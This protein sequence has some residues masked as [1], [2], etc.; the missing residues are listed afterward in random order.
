ME[1]GRFKCNIWVKSKRWSMKEKMLLDAGEKERIWGSQRAAQHPTMST[2]VGVSRVWSLKGIWGSWKSPDAQV[3][4]KTW[5]SAPIV[6]QLLSNANKSRTGV[7][8]SPRAHDEAHQG[9]G[10]RGRGISMAMARMWM[11]MEL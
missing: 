3:D 9:R 2:K 10:S 11:C 5:I 4:P 6:F 7:P 8:S 1:E